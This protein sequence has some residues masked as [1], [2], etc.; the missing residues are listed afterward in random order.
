MATKHRTLVV[1]AIVALVLVTGESASSRPQASTAMGALA[2]S[3]AP[4][5]WAE[6]TTDNIVPTLRAGG[7]SGAIFGYSEDGA[8]DPISRQWLYC[9]GDHGEAPRFVAYSADTNA[10]RIMPHPAWMS[11]TGTMHGYDHNA[12]NPATG[13][14]YHYPAG[15]RVLQKYSV[16]SGTWTTTPA[17]PFWDYIAGYMGVE[18]FPE[19]GGIVV[20]NGGGGSGFVYLFRESTQAWSTLAGGLPMG[21]YQNFA[22]Y[23]P[24]HRVMILGGGNSSSDLYKVDATGT[25]TTQ[26]P[27]PV[28]AGVKHHSIVTVDP[29]SGDY[30]IF[31]SD[32]KFYVY[33][34]VTDTW[35]LQGGTVPIFTPTRDNAIWHV[36]ASPVSTYGVTMFVKFFAA[37]PSRA[38]VYLYKHAAGLPP[39]TTTPPA[40]TPGPTTGGAAPA[41]P[42][43]PE[44]ENGDGALNDKLCGAFGVEALLLLGLACFRRRAPAGKAVAR[45]CV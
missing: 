26:R 45:R 31:T 9:G 3:M 16:A 19:L 25:V 38:W 27:A 32:A 7:A 22:E 41:A 28:M 2:A 44:G 6:L 30:L 10:W 20:A 15:A 34:V 35:T 37:D 14:F 21:A 40:P 5:T 42:G 8:W 1:L 39:A 17:M 13:D 24:V 43:D 29:V 4:G 23:N 36:D 12:I 33:D 11:T 18:Y